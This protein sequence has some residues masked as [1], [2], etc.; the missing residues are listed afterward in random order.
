MAVDRG[1]IS[2]LLNE[3]LGFA[4][5]TV[6]QFSFIEVQFTTRRMISKQYSMFYGGVKIGIKMF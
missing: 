3:F 2:R 4:P 6:K 1:K 5:T